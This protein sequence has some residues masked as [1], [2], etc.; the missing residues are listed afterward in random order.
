MRVLLAVTQRQLMAAVVV[1]VHLTQVL[2]QPLPTAAEVVAAVLVL[3]RQEVW[4]VAVLVLRVQAL[5]AAMLLQTRAA[6]AVERRLLRV[7]HL[8][9]V[10]A[11]QA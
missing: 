7:A 11:A 5:T 10:T 3:V 8:A 9:V 4:A 2:D 6:A 1:R